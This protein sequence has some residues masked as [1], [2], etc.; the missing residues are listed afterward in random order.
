[1][2]VNRTFVLRF[3]SLAMLAVG[4]IVSSPANPSHA[5]HDGRFVWTNYFVQA[6]IEDV[7]N[8]PLALVRVAD[9]QTQVNYHANI[10]TQAVARWNATNRVRFVYDVNQPTVVCDVA[11]FPTVGN[12]VSVI[13]EASILTGDYDRN[14]QLDAFRNNDWGPESSAGSTGMYPMT[15]GRVRLG[16]SYDNS[17]N[18]LTHE[19]GHAAG[20]SD[21]YIVGSSPC[22]DDNPY[23][24]V[25]VM[26]CSTGH[27]PIPQVIDIDSLNLMYQ[28]IP[29]T[30]PVTGNPPAAPNWRVDSVTTNSVTLKWTDYSF[31]EKDQIITRTADG[32]TAVAARDAESFTWSG[33]SSGV[34]YCFNIKQRN[35][36]GGTAAPSP[37][38]CATTTANPADPSNVRVCSIPCDLYGFK[39]NATNELGFGVIVQKRPTCSTGS[40][41][42]WGQNILLPPKNQTDD[43]YVYDFVGPGCFRVRVQ[44]LGPG[45]G[46]SNLITSTGVYFPN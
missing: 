21:L 37:D 8:T 16:T 30:I 31:N 39:D 40:W 13:Y 19:L 12:V 41:G 35:G 9:C 6:F 7:P 3:A 38:V 44:A 10:I 23:G 28:R 5:S 32:A 27:D 1:M 46:L 24:G 11:G 45:G 42:N 43:V 17:V 14:Q 15:K 2:R 22:V 26:D 29:Q 18:G 33:L 25:T 20:L 34:N 36:Y 4:V